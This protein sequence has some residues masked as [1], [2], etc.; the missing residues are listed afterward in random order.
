[1]WVEAL[2]AGS[3]GGLRRLGRELSLDLVSNLPLWL[4]SWHGVTPVLFVNSNLNWPLNLRYNWVWISGSAVSTQEQMFSWGDQLV[5]NQSP[6][7][8][9]NED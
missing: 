7:G 2:R 6:V 1:M 5:N 4:G 8:K 3:S 9:W